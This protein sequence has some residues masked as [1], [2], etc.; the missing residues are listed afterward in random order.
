MLGKTLPPLVKVGESWEISG[1][2]KNHS[3]ACTPVFSEKTLAQILQSYGRELLGSTVKN[4]GEF[5]LLY[6]LI[7]A[8]DKLSVQVHPSDADAKANGWGPFGK[9]EC[10]YIVHAGPGAQLVVGF[11]KGVSKDD[12]AAAVKNVTLTDL[13]EF[14]DIKAGD[15]VFIPAGTVHAICSNTVIYEV[16]QT[17]DVTFRLYDWGRL[18]STGKSRTLHVKE[19]LQ[20]LDTRWHA[21]YTI[22]PV[23]M[24]TLKNGRRTMRIACR[25]FAIE[26]YHFHS[27]GAVRIPRRKSFSVI[28]VLDGSVA[29]CGAN[30]VT[31]KK[32]MSALFP[33][34]MQD[35]D[36]RTDSHARFLISWVPDLRQEVFAPLKKLG[37][38]KD[39][40]AA[41]GGF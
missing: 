20:V 5:P 24:E 21:S 18:D 16:Q 32:G 33:A 37:I 7:D 12:V 36:I 10:W 14:H 38:S 19:S 6:K 28:M 13:L 8:H 40:I 41:L 27:P 39:A 23:R 35:I 34:A 15:M 17:S 11:K 29:V 25:Y 2:E 31:L 26:E 22:P 3:I 4:T 1:V 9:T 30:P